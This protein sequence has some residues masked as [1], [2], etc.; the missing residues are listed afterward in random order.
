[1]S[2]PGREADGPHESESEDGPNASS[3]PSSSDG[4]ETGGGRT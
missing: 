1:M 4:R 2:P 3:Q